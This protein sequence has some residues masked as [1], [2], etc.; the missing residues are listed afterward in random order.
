MMD[1]ATGFEFKPEVTLT[2]LEDSSWSIRYDQTLFNGTGGRG[3][4]GHS[5]TLL[6]AI[7]EI[8]RTFPDGEICLTI[9]QPHVTVQMNDNEAVRKEAMN[10]CFQAL[11]DA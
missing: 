1:A 11:Q 5:D 7:Q 9:I 6:G 3:W 10:N 8:A 2:L 4:G